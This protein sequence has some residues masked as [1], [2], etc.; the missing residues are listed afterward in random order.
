MGRGRSSVIPGTARMA[1]AGVGV[2]EGSGSGGTVSRTGAGS[3]K[4]T[5][6]IRPGTT[7]SPNS[8]SVGIR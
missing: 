5:V 8:T 4:I 1:M 6:E 3:A 7:P 2:E